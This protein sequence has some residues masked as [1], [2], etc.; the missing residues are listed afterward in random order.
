MTSP[1]G[2]VHAL[3]STR[4]AE[5]GFDGP[6]DIASIGAMRG[7]W[8]V[9]GAC[10]WVCVSAIAHADGP[11]SADTARADQLFQEARTLIDAKRVAEACPKLQESQRLDPRLGTL[12]HL[13]ACHQVQGR[14][15]AAWIEF[16]EAAAQAA[17]QKQPEREAL[18]RARAAELERSLPR[19]V[20]ELPKGTAPSDVRVRL[21][22]EVL[23]PGVV[24][25]PLPLDAG[26]HLVEVSAPGKR[27]WAKPF[28]VGADRVTSTVTVPPLESDAG[29]QP[30]PAA[31]AAPPA[32]TPPADD[33]SLRT[34]GWIV[35]G[36]GV[37][38][39]GVGTFF[40]LRAASQR[41]EAD[42]SCAGRFCTDEG[43]AGHDRARTSALVS[44]VG[45]GVGIAAAAVGVTL[46]VWPR[47]TSSADTAMG[48]TRLTFDGRSAHAE[49]SW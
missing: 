12:L 1:P 5:E 7:L 8:T 31:P 4:P 17:R 49:M 47:R 25:A 48:T 45:F 21:D 26:R 41:D 2:G 44:T 42:R 6:E 15:V 38:G 27:A 24:G 20:I 34:V 32:P 35:T 43:L 9:G 16:N 13:A 28:D 14:S 36:A 46:L 33:G 30:P 29:P 18:A 19:V 22:G 23:T 3:Q 40:G 10:A 11:T 37:V 39:L